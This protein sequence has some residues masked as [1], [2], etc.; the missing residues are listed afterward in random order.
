MLKLGGGGRLLEDRDLSAL[1]TLLGTDPIANCTV[2]SRVEN[3]GLDRRRLGGELWGYGPGGA[4]HGRLIGACFAGAN[5]VPVGSS[6]AALRSFADR[7]IRHGR[8][9]SSIVGPVQAVMPLWSMLEPEW[10]PA[11]AIRACQPLLA[12]RVLATTTPDP[13]VRR[14]RPDE[15]E[16][17]LP[18]CVAMFTEE[19]GVSPVGRDGGALYRARVAETIAAGRAFARIENGQVIFKAELGAVSRQACQVQGVWVD[20]AHR[21]RG[22]CQAGMAAVIRSALTEVAPVVS[23][24][25]NDF[26]HTARAAYHRVGL[27]EV[28]TF[29]SVMF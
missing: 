13:A 19:V 22:I 11:R 27:R 8:R 10:G 21:G 18:A 15:L 17:F 12:T 4:G 6:P 1:H 14:V 9:C 23:L 26:N 16:T 24:Y 20:P 28:G 25:V 7:A 29:M 3:V 5:L 2:A